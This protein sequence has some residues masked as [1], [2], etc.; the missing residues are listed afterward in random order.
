MA[1]FPDLIEFEWDKMKKLK[2]TIVLFYNVAW[3]EQHES[4][5]MLFRP[6]FK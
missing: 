5:F 3:T 1:D 6:M 4:F 2:K